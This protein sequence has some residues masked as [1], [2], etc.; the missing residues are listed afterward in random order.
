MPVRY[1]ICYSAGSCR[2]SLL[3]A[4]YLAQHASRPEPDVPRSWLV[5]AWRNGELIYEAGWRH[6]MPD[7]S[8]RTMKRRL[9]P[10]WLEAD[11][12]ADTASAVV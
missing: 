10:A 12:K 2:Y 7:G 1:S 8:Q 3:L 4:W 11:G 9:G 6:R 5:V